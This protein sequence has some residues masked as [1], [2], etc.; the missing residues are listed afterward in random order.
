M[1][2]VAFEQLTFAYSYW[3]FNE[4]GTMDTMISETLEKIERGVS[5]P[6]DAMK[7]LTSD[8]KAEIEANLE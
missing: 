1:W 8:L 7:T 5:S 6:D 2:R 3:H 4:M